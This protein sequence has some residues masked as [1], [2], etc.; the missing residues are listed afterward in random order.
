MN[1]YKLIAKKRDGHALT[2]DEIESIINDYHH[3]KIPDYQ[4]SAF[5]MAIY[6]QGMN[7]KETFYL[8]EAMMNSGKVLK[9]PFKTY[10]K[11]STGG[12][13]DKISIILAPILAALGL[14]IPMIAGKGLGH[15]G[16]T[17]DK[18]ESIPG[19]NPYLKLKSFQ[20][21]VRE[22]G[23][24]INGQTNELAP[25]D[26]KLY[27][28][29]DV[30]ATVPSVPLI[31]ASILSKKLAEGINGLVMDIKYGSAA[32]MK[33]LESAQNL[34]ISIQNTAKEFD[35]SIH[36]IVTKMEQPLGKMIGN[37]LEII[38]CIDFLENKSQ[39]EDITVLTYMM[40]AILLLES[41]HTDNFEDAFG[42][43]KNVISNGEALNKFLEMIKSQDSVDFDLESFKNKNQAPFQYH[44]TAEKNGFIEN[45]DALKLGQLCVEIHAGRK[46][47]NEILDYFAGVEIYKKQNDSVRKGDRILTVYYSDKSH[48]Q[49]IKE[50]LKDLVCISE[51][52]IEAEPLIAELI[53]DSIKLTK[54]EINQLRIKILDMAKI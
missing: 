48:L 49:L 23:L 17:V 22:I 6:F 42:K 8:T 33:D 50:M 39:D 27:A 16:G 24:S 1:F 18:L 3:E 12:V 30:T 7:S 28:L 19:F 10:D 26:K 9:W 38:E 41:G 36:S 5:A 35:K 45:V 53:S 15:T 29:R 51:Q 11:H 32:F 20:K 44:L 21:Q 34:A 54:D 43:I 14:K 37:Q 40:A 13:G 31:T 4:M 47:L 25:A 46:F 52:K 2:K